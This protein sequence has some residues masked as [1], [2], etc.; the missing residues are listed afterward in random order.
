ME[1]KNESIHSLESRMFPNQIYTIQ[2]DLTQSSLNNV[3]AGESLTAT[4]FQVRGNQVDDD[5]DGQLVIS[6]YVL[7]SSYTN[8]NISY[9]Q[10]A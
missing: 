9:L 10:M 5:N 8:I 4:V 7:H 3:V 2:L 1:K 6:K